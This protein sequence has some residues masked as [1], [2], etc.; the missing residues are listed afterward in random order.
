MIKRVILAAAA[1]TL[2]ATQ[3]YAGSEAETNYTGVCNSCHNPA[4]APA[5]KAP[6]LGDKAAWGPRIAKGIDAL[7]H[8]ALNGS[9]ANPTM[10]PKGGA[11]HLSDQQIKD[12]VDYMVSKAQ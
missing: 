7:Y 9:T 5:L 3:L 6:G 10:M 4:V 2:F 12:I 11:M 1:A 8:T